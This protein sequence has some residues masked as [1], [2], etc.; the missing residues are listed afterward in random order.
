MGRACSQNGGRQVPGTIRTQE[1]VNLHHFR[2]D[3]WSS[4]LWRCLPQMQVKRQELITWDHAPPAR[5][6]SCTLMPAMKALTNTLLLLSLKFSFQ[7]CMK[8]L[9]ATRTQTVTQWK[10][11]NNSSMIYYLIISV[12]T[13]WNFIKIKVLFRGT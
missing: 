5:K 8:C 7:A 12:R 1:K 13:V 6:T 11:D 9:E 10:L 2:N 4:H 3:S